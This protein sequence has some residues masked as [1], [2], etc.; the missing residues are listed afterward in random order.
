MGRTGVVKVVVVYSL[1]MAG[2]QMGVDA[3]EEFLP[4]WVR[5][6]VGGGYTV[7]AACTAL[8]LH[9]RLMSG[10]VSS[11]SENDDKNKPQNCRT[12]R[13]SKVSGHLPPRYH[14]S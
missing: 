12:N 14:Q 3:Y 4:G 10:S 9:K 5:M 13:D 6:L 8:K 2:I 1:G 11:L 7:L